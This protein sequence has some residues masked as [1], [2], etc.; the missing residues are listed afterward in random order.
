MTVLQ[1]RGKWD[2]KLHNGTTV[3]SYYQN[4]R[5]HFAIFITLRFYCVNYK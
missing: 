1:N 2:P 5:Q 3:Y 4:I